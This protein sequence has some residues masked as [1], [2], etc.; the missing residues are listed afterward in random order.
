MTRI[1]TPLRPV[2]APVVGLALLLAACSGDGESTTGGTTADG[3]TTTAGEPTT[4]TTVPPTPP[5]TSDPFDGPPE[6]DPP[7]E[8]LPSIGDL[9]PLTG[10]DLEGEQPPGVAV[11][12]VKID[13]HPES[14]PPT[15]L[16]EADVVFEEDVEGVT[17][18]VALFHSTQPTT[19]GP[20]RSART[21]DLPIL[22][23]LNRPILA[24]SGG[25]D[26]V[27]RAMANAD[28]AGVLRD[29][30][31][32]T[33]VDCYRRDRQRPRPH[34]LY[35]DP[36]CLR[37]LA[38]DAGPARPLWTFGP[39]PAGITGTPTP[40]VSVAMEGVDVGWT[41]DEGRT[42]YLRSQNGRNHVANSGTRI[43]A[44]NVVVMTVDYGLS[45]ADRRSPEAH[46][47]GHGPLVVHR[48]GVAITGNWF[49]EQLTEPIGLFDDAGNEI[50]L[51]PG[52]T[53]VELV[54][55]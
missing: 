33:H 46:T 2:L 7:F 27:T 1:R 53:F 45:P 51:T 31:E 5:T 11:L 30:G 8:P 47:V 4:T 6:W 55:G 9:A 16:D 19:I 20:V 24:W 54:A 37:E 3:S 21:S 41:W 42:R 36:E 43:G 12:A 32:P 14:R 23:A 40:E 52:V 13:N 15:A 22:A 17:R 29:R 28:D 39:L 50:P 35:V 26:Y 18:F 44:E 38:P 49:R 25:N 34:N 10:R 48:D